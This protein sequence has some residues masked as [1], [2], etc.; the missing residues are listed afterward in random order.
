MVK[1][2]QGAKSEHSVSGPSYNPTRQ[3]TSSS[4]GLDETRDDSSSAS[5]SRREI[6]DATLAGKREHALLPPLRSDPPAS[7]TYR[8]LAHSLEEF[9]QQEGGQREVRL[10]EVW[11]RLAEA[12]GG[13]GKERASSV[14][15]P[16]PTITGDVSTEAPIFTREKAERLQDLY[17][18]ELSHKCGNGNCSNHTHAPRPPIP[19]KDFHRYAEAKEV[20]ELSMSSHLGAFSYLIGISYRVVAGI[21]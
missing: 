10:K 18:H 19:W 9:R 5:L 11:Q 6:F 12:R 16:D 13:K 2:V 17:D 14:R 3:P 20:G 21:S 7:K 1:N 4:V 15:L 8:R